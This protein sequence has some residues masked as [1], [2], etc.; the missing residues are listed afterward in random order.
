MKRLLSILATL[1][2]IT[3]AFAGNVVFK[4]IWLEHNVLQDGQNG[5]K[6]HVAFSIY[7]MQGQ[8]CSAIA[9]F[10]YP[11]G[12]GVK[13]TNGRYCT[14]G[15]TVCSS[16][17]FTPNYSNTSFSDLSIFIPNSELH[18][19]SGKRTYYTRVF[20]QAPD[21]NFIGNSDFASFD[22]TGANNNASLFSGNEGNSNAKKQTV[23]K[24]N[25][26]NGHEYV[27]LGLPSGTKWATMNIGAKDAKKLGNMYSWGE[28]SGFNNGKRD[29]SWNT[30]KYCKSS[31]DALTKYNYGKTDNK[32]ELDLSDD[33]AYTEWGSRWRIPSREQFE[34][35]LDS[36][37][38]SFE[39]VSSSNETDTSGYLIKS[40]RNGKTIFLPAAGCISGT[41][42]KSMNVQGYYWT[43]S[44][45]WQTEN[46]EDLGD[47]FLSLFS[48]KYNSEPNK[49]A[50]S[51]WFSMLTN[52]INASSRCNG[53]CIRPVTK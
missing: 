9:Y 46:P 41:E 3:T 12:T 5:M 51:F 4:K 16:C 48:G 2:M 22:G 40:K 1:V 43:R 26:I 50:Y 45:K 15:G 7:G 44:L 18:L 24:S 28:T 11:Q 32:K 31:S 25:T 53:M 17:T 30:Y 6:V 19:L 8:K 20:I 37:N 42:F 33:V 35:L 29:F 27:D 14:T 34:E 39:Y 13:D 38:C 52:D 49:S 23:Q 36:K 10:D 47:V 21:G